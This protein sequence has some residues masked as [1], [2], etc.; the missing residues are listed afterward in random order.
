[1]CDSD[2]DTSFATQIQ[3]GRQLASGMDDDGSEWRQGVIT[4]WNARASK[5]KVQYSDDYEWMMWPTKLQ[6]EISSRPEDV[7]IEAPGFTVRC[8]SCGV[9]HD[10]LS[11]WTH[12]LWTNDF[13]R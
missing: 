13:S 10:L 1:M 8:T 2:R 9:D 4:S 11:F 5:Y 3:G 7:S 6:V 12:V